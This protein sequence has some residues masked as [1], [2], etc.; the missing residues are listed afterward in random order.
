MRS[1]SEELLCAFELLKPLDGPALRK[2]MTKAKRKR[3]V[4]KYR[5]RCERYTHLFNQHD[6]RNITLHSPLDSMASSIQFCGTPYLLLHLSC[7]DA[8]RSGNRR[9][10][11]EIQGVAGASSASVTIYNTLPLSLYQQHHHG[12]PRLASNAN[13]LS[14]RSNF[15]LNLCTRCMIRRLRPCLYTLYTAGTCIILSHELLYSCSPPSLSLHWSVTPSLFVLNYVCRYSFFLT[16][17]TLLEC[18][19]HL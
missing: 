2:E 5:K 16:M 4:S 3:L 7:C 10:F 19:Y 1:V 15:G 13:L 12:E 18:V 14:H 8:H 17:F 11:L 9:L 6:G